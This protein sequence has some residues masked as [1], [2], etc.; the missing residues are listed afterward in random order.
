MKNKKIQI[1]IA[2]MLTCLVVMTIFL[3]TKS[4]AEGVKLI[5]LE[6]ESAKLMSENHELNDRI[7]SSTSL[8][9]INKEASSKGMIKP[10]NFLYI[11]GTGI[12]MR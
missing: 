2:G 12:A 9:A 6:N 1:I 10:E 8:S 4:S 3:A 11:N 7:I 5:A